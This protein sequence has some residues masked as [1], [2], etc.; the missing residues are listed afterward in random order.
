MTPPEARLVAALRRAVQPLV[1]P[2]LPVGPGVTGHANT[3]TI[4]ITTAT[5][6]ILPVGTKLVLPAQAQV[7]P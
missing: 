3:V 4:T 7:A 1:H 2:P 5:V 6:P